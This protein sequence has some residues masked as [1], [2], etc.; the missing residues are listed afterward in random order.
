MYRFIATKATVSRETN[1]KTKNMNPWIWHTKLPSAQRPLMRATKDNGMQ[2]K[3]IRMSDAER[4]RMKRLVEIRRRR[5]FFATATQTKRFPAN[6][7]KSISERDVDSKITCHLGSEE[8]WLWRLEV[9]VDRFILVFQAWR[10]L[11][12]QNWSYFLPFL[13]KQNPTEL[14]SSM[15]RPKMGQFVN[16][17]VLML[18][19]IPFFLSTNN[20]DRQFIW[21]F[22]VTKALSF[23]PN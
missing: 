15:F 22:A 21:I 2:V 12:L 9:F 4:E 19:T 18:H 7:K 10:R 3:A 6:A 8:S 14:I 1:A 23:P 16:Y 11:Q 17:L 5:Q 13:R 20:F